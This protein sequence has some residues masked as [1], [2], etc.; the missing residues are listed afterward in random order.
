M[1]TGL[2]PTFPVLIIDDETDVI[3]SLESLLKSIGINN[4]I[5]CND[6]RKVM[7]LLVNE[8]VSIVLLDLLM[9]YI[10]GEELI[11][12]INELYPYLS[13]IVI[14]GSNKIETAVNCMKFGAYDFLTKPIDE[15]LF[16]NVIKRAIDIMELK[17]E[18]KK[19]KKH[20]LT[21][22]LEYPE[23]FS[24]IITKNKMMLSVFQY[25]EAIAG[26]PEPI[27]ITGE[28]GVGKELIARAIHSI[29]QRTGDFIPINIGG[30]D[31]TVFSDTLFGHRKGAYT[32]AD[33]I[34]NGLIE[35]ARGGTL[36]LDEIGDLPIESQI[37]L[38]R[39]L[40]EKEYYPLGSDLPYL[41]EARII[42]STNADIEILMNNNKFR[43][44]L[45]YRLNTHHIHIP[46]LRERKEDI[47]LL[48]E[49]FFEEASKIY[50]KK[51][52]TPPKELYNLLAFYHFPGNIRELRSMIFDAIGSHKTKML[53]LKIFKDRIL[54]NSKNF[55][56]DSGNFE[57]IENTKITF[58]EKLPTLK[59]T[60]Q[61]LIKEALDRTNGS[62]ALAA[63]LLGISP[64]AL[65]KRL[66]N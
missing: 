58:P 41:S 50:N 30:L 22:K 39:L 23:V 57:N 48:V 62:Q 3:I 38:L 66:K 61:I 21:S 10:T 47:P 12:Q 34:R 20:I 4:I 65:S 49:Y 24:D 42:A 8:N 16:I 11:K 26:S 1:K 59:E 45:Y 55:K 15:S 14:T 25:I 32:G 60:N 46:P 36:F 51:K 37:K 28:S 40:Q 29:S 27:L 18:I 44:D 13:V 17:L 35:K 63:R 7:D 54:K 2:Y 33:T 64:Q 6:S 53:S 31:D 56:E 19:L 9:P 43:K 52:P 5:C